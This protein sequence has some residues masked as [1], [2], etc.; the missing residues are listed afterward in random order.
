MMPQPHHDCM[1][2]ARLRDPRPTLF[3]NGSPDKDITGGIIPQETTGGLR[4]MV[5]NNTNKTNAIRS[6]VLWWLND[7]VCLG[8]FRVETQPCR[9]ALAMN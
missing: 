6:R 3:Q 1:P 5:Q 4:I 2:V 7:A 9:S 8:V